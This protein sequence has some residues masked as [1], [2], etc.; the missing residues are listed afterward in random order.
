MTLILARVDAPLAIENQFTRTQVNGL[1]AI[2]SASKVTAA[3]GARLDGRVIVALSP[4]VIWRADRRESCDSISR[5]CRCR[6]GRRDGWAANPMGGCD[7]S[8]RT[9]RL[10]RRRG[11]IGA[12]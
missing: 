3:L 1:S 9:A 12:V 5:C 6:C 4:A 11:V 2:G 7:S 8:S 10:R